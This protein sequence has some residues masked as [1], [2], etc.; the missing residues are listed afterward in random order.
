MALFRRSGPQPDPATPVLADRCWDDPELD[1]AVDAVEDT[2]KMPDV[3]IDAALD[4]IARVRD[5]PERHVQGVEAMAQ[6]LTRCLDVVRER[7]QGTEQQRTAAATDAAALLSTTLVERA[8]QVRGAGGSD[9]ADP[10]AADEFLDLLGQADEI[11][12]GALQLDPEHA[13]SGC[14]LLRTALGLGVPSDEWWTRFDAARRSRPTLYPAHVTMLMALCRKWYG[15]SEAMWR[16]ARDVAAAAPEGDPV[17]AMLPLAHAEHFVELRINPPQQGNATDAWEQARK[18]DEDTAFASAL[19]WL[20]QDGGQ[21]L[22]HPRALEAHQLFG[23]F[24]SPSDPGRARWHFEQ[25]GPRMA[26]YPWRYLSGR[27]DRSYAK[28]LTAVGIEGISAG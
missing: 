8:W 2:S 26:R 3:R 27:P 10:D 23:W 12:A 14:V 13:P 16:F 21:R 6:R 17:V 19:H 25:A 9:G 4:F 24:F 28:A 22:R 15:S 20:G 18:Q 11:A 5:D 1:S 7:A